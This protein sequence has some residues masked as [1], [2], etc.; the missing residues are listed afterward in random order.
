MIFGQKEFLIKNQT[1]E[2][3]MLILQEFPNKYQGFQSRWDF[4]QLSCKDNLMTAQLVDHGYETPRA[5]GESDSPVYSIRLDASGEDASL[6]WSL[7][8]KKPKRN[9]SLLL[10]ISL[11][12]GRFAVYFSAHGEEAVLF[13]GI[14]VFCLVLFAAWIL[15][16]I[17]HDKASMDV[18]RE[19]LDGNF[20]QKLSD[21]TEEAA[22]PEKS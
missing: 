5:K 4:E 20:S 12:L 17:C 1:P 7:R 11:I 21:L 8:W 10:I 16:N 6:T 14:W 19:M 2:K 15:Q 3:A 22:A 18:F 9:L 13:M